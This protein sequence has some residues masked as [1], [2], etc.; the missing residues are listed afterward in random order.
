MNK[1]QVFTAALLLSLLMT[2]FLIVFLAW[3]GFVQAQ[4]DIDETGEGLANT[5]QITPENEEITPFIALET[6]TVMTGDGIAGSM[7]ELESASPAA[8]PERGVNMSHWSILG[9]NLL[10]RD[11]ALQY[12]YTVNGCIY[13]TNSGGST[14][15][16]FPVT[17]PDRSIIKSMDI[18]YNDTSSSNLIVYLSR[19]VPGQSANDILIVSSQ[20]NTGWGSNSSA[21]VTHVVDNSSWTYA[22]NYDWTLTN[23]S[24]Q[25]CGIRINYIYPFYS[26]YL[27]SIQLGK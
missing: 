9:S 19:Y 13:I 2:G 4:S 22:I 8:S 18:F 17:L 11:S 21:E 25:I 5:T 27:P 7:E 23:S 10:P 20:G 12:A 24:L 14:R 1:K 16:Q 3:G 15:M 6:D 26:T